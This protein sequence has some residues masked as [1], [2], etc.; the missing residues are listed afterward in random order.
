MAWVCSMKSLHFGCLAFGRFRPSVIRH[1][2]FENV[3]CRFFVPGK[4]NTL[5]CRKSSKNGRNSFLVGG[6]SVLKFPKHRRC[7][8]GGNLF[9]TTSSHHC[10]SDG[11]HKQ[12]PTPRGFK[13]FYWWSQPICVVF[14]DGALTWI[15]EQKPQPVLP[16]LLNPHNFSVGNVSDVKIFQK[17]EGNVDVYTMLTISNSSRTNHFI[18]SGF[19]KKNGFIEESL[20]GFPDNLSEKNSGALALT[21]G[22]SFLKKNLHGGS[23]AKNP[24]T[25]NKIITIQYKKKKKL[26]KQ[27]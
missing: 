9:F 13:N 18:V 17:R 26:N 5:F 6:S 7:D 19:W 25:K 14:F 15:F 1:K 2:N 24:I 20:S 16:F 12:T 3:Y 8:Q 11:I 27:S 23:L 21:R 22:L 10:T 4:L